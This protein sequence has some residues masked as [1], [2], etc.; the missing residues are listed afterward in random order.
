MGVYFPFT[1]IVGQREMKLAIILGLINPNIGGILIQGEKGTGKSTIVRSISSL[2]PSIKVY[3]LPLSSDVESIIGGIDLE[4]A[5]IY[6]KPVLYEGLISKANSGILYIDEVNLL[7]DYLI[8][9]ILSAHSSGVNIVE[10]EGISKKQM[11]KFFLI[12]TMNPEEG[13]IRPQL[14]DRFGLCVKVKSEKDPYKRL[15]ILDRRVLFEM[16][17]QSFTKQY[18]KREIRLRNKII[19]ARKILNTI[20]LKKELKDIIVKICTENNVA[21]HRAEIVMAEAAMAYAAF[22]GHREVTIKDINA[23]AEFVLCHRRQNS[24]PPPKTQDKQD[25][26][27]TKTKNNKQDNSDKKETPNNTN[28]KN[29]SPDNLENSAHSASQSQI[30]KSKEDREKIYEIGPVFRTRDFASKKDRI[31]RKGSG[32]RSKT[33]TSLKQGRYVRARIAKRVE[34][35]A[36][37]ATIRAAAPYQKMRKKQP[38]VLITITREDIR[39]KVREK[40]VGNLL[41][42]VVDASGSMG[43]QA[44]MIATKGAIMSLLLNAYQKRD[45][46]GMISFRRNNATLMLPPTSSVERAVKLLKELPVGGK[47]PLS[48]ALIKA[49]DI[50]RIELIKDPALRPII[51]IVTDGKANV[52]LYCKNPIDDMLMVAQ[53]I[54]KYY[55]ADYVVVDTEDGSK[56]SLGL[57]RTLADI[58]GAYY[59]KLHEL[60]AQ[61][62]VDAVGEII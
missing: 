50:V 14:L 3:T 51:I 46:I 2:M 55:Q 40:K 12:G 44:R 9:T 47:T 32:K 6:G 25:K 59:F 11:A 34:D 58:L 30:L 49:M 56:M 36:I 1:A 23:V 42:F 45:R 16:D 35:I 10:R 28:K 53:K 39:Q 33:L 15:K 61:D 19:L 62:L 31:Y 26:A 22:K 13:D 18:L 60:R 57:G 43:A 7:H 52:P 41:L 20:T 8:E 4:K 5:I 27:R 29:L 38:G 21:G 54:K 48:H 24:A 37:D 17:P